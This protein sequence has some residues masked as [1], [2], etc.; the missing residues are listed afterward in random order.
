[1]YSVPNLISVLKINT[2]NTGDV[3]SKQALVSMEVVSKAAQ[4]HAIYLF[5]LITASYGPNSSAWHVIN[6]RIQPHLLFFHIRILCVCSSSTLLL[7]PC[8]QSCS[9]SILNIHWSIHH[10]LT[11]DKSGMWSFLG[12]V[13][14]LHLLYSFTK[15]NK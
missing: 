1:M 9:I 8:F 5:K 12:T 13:P 10:P 14:C 2:M 3:L 7:L 11:N 15:G 4:H 6:I